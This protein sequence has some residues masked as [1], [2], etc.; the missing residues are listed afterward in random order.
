MTDLVPVLLEESTERWS[1]FRLSDG[2][3]LLIKCAPGRIQRVEGQFNDMGEPIYQIAGWQISTQ[4]KEC[5]E[6]LR[7]HNQ[8]QGVGN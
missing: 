7:A 5:P 1:E 4:I 8:T 6:L 2:V 3:T